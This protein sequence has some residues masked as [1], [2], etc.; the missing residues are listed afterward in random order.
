[1]A[2]SSSSSSSTSGRL[3]DVYISVQHED[4]RKYITDMIDKSLITRGVPTFKDNKQLRRRQKGTEVGKEL[5]DAIGM[6]RISIVL[7]SKEY[8]S[9]SWCLE[10]L[11]LILGCRKKWGL[12]VLP[13][14]FDVDPSDIRKQRG[15]AAKVVGIQR[16]GSFWRRRWT[17]ALTEA[18]NLCGWDHRASDRIESMLV[19]R[20]VEDIINK[21][22]PT[23]LIISIY[24]LRYDI[25]HEYLKL[26]LQV[27]SKDVII[28]GICGPRRMG[29]TAIAKAI[30]NQIFYT[31]EGSSFLSDVAQNSKQ[32]NG[33]VYL[34]EKL[35]SDIL[36]ERDIAIANCTR[37][38]DIIKEKLCFKR[39]LIV[40]DDVDDLEQLYA[41]IGSRNWFG[42][43]SKIIITT[44][45]VHLLNALGVDQILLA[46]GRPLPPNIE[47][48]WEKYQQSCHIVA[49]F[50][51]YIQSLYNM[52]NDRV[53][54]LEN[55]L[56]K[57]RQE[58]AVQA[59][60]TG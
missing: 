43:G 6:S 26:F 8:V 51:E 20:V 50:Q 48:I 23:N 11:A 14:F 16:P 42:V 59:P 44:K 2:V 30:Y 55:C 36:S 19:G 60:P 4:P 54:Y 34:Q 7:F 31:F 9:S 56:L 33:L 22:I 32:P 24:P 39:V 57:E 35:L 25:C 21:R 37:G 47:D 38:M 45:K 27:G 53:R 52:R 13:I 17:A 29:K 12:I 41:L 46:Q 28:V 10:E 40:L 18:A 3:H 49:G 1:M 15:S 58:N 5:Q